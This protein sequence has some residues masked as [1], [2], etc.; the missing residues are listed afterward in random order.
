VEWLKYA[1]R[2]AAA[3]VLLAMAA[4]M[5][6]AAATVPDA[7]AVTLSIAA[8]M[9][10]GCFFVWP[11][12]PNAWRKDPPTNRQLAYAATLGITVP[13]RATKGQVSDL[14]SASTGR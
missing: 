12:R 3:V 13:R 10:L 7:R 14:I 1:V 5:L 11:R 9:A 4:A 8:V 6:I 2:L